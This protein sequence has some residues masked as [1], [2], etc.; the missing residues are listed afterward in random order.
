MLATR[1]CQ[2][3]GEDWHDDHTLVLYKGGGYDG[4]LWE[5]NAAVFDGA[6]T[7][8]NLLSSGRNG[9]ETE[10]ELKARIKF[11]D[12]TGQRNAYYAYRIDCDEC[13]EEF[14]DN[15]S[16]PVIVATINKLVER[17]FVAM[18]DRFV[19]CTICG[20]TNARANCITMHAAPA[21]DQLWYSCDY[22]EF[23]CDECYTAG[24]CDVCDAFNVGDHFTAPHDFVEGLLPATDHD[25]HP[26][27]R[28]RDV[29]QFHGNVCEYCHEELGDAIGIP[30]RDEWEDMI[31]Q[32][33]AGGYF[34]G[35][36][37]DK[38][39][40]VVME[41]IRAKVERDFTGLFSRVY[42]WQFVFGAGVALKARGV[43][44]T[45]VNTFMHEFLP[46]RYHA[47]TSHSQHPTSSEPR[48]TQR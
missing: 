9:C 35:M 14:I 4:C 47:T 33:E 24:H 12:G 46:S 3:N 45:T 36:L 38:P 48:M 43:D 21:D 18:M 1:N 5:W 32:E 37:H 28:S 6:T 7:F 41:L 40:S 13:W 42:A 44:Q 22:D 34:A 10:D 26:R 27:R 2:H 31:T 23:V 39:E 25:L 19:Q 30:Q 11:I 29:A 17:G 15:H 8:H 20:E 16:K